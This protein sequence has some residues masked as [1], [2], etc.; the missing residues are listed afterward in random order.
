MT[1]KVRFRPSVL[2]LAGILILQLVLLVWFGCQK[3]GFH[4]DEIATFTLSNHTDGFFFRTE[5]LMNRWVDGSAFEDVLTVSEE[6]RFDYQMVYRNQ[7]SDV[8]PALYYDMIHT[9]SSLFQGQFSKWIGLIPNIAFCLL[10]T[11][12]MFFLS[13]RLMKS[14]ALA[15]VAAGAWAFSIGAVD[16]ATFVRMYAM[17]TL[18]TVLLAF[19]HLKAAEQMTAG[20]KLSVRLLVLLFLNTWAGLLT[21]YYFSVF[22]LFLCGLF[23]LCLLFA[24][25]WRDAVCYLLA[26]FGAIG[27]ALLSFP[28]MLNH[29]FGVGYRGL[30][31]FENLNKAG[32]LLEEY[33]EVFQIISNDLLNGWALELILLCAALLGFAALR[34]FLR[35]ISVKHEDGMLEFRWNRKYVSP[36][37]CNFSHSD[38]TIRIPIHGILA[39]GAGIVFLLYSLL[40]SKIAPYKSDRYYMCLYPLFILCAVYFIYH[41]FV[42]VFRNQNACKAAAALLFAAVCFFGFLHQTPGYLYP[43]ASGRAKALENHSDLPVI[44]INDAYHWYATRWLTEYPDHPDGYVCEYKSSFSRLAEAAEAHDLTDGFL[45]YALRFP[46]SDEQLISRVQEHLSLKDCQTLWG[47]E[48]R[49]FLCTLND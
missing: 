22:A 14:D 4:E 21:Q 23:M 31:A 16:T 28:T 7:E 48:D 26:E 18:L 29:I 43:D 33:K 1:R 35:R 3:Q 9:L 36:P 2:L 8:H 10:T 37:R 38:K 11:A 25:R 39:A 17:L 44:V 19:L 32:N 20:P 15:A 24:R 49:V 27:A 47:G 34:G 42:L 40:I 41:I 5:S 46:D 12:V 13:K 30:E 45:L 6:E